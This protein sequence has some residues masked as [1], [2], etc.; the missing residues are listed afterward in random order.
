MF[1]DVIRVF[2]NSIMKDGKYLLTRWIHDEKDDVTHFY[3]LLQMNDR[4]ITA[5]VGV[6]KF[7]YNEKKENRF[8]KEQDEQLGY[9]MDILGNTM[10]Q[11]DSH[12]E[13][14]MTDPLLK[15]H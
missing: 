15:K 3:H 4:D 2:E 12:G 5:I 6:L 14:V 13:P 11:Y 10:I 9:L 1:E 8:T 7:L